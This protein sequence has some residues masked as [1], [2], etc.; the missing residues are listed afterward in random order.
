MGHSIVVIV[1]GS[2]SCMHALKS[3]EARASPVSGAIAEAKL[4]QRFELAKCEPFKF[5][6][7]LIR[8]QSDRGAL[9]ICCLLS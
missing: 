3:G 8:H 6:H 2:S 1:D 4:C 5:W 7:E 9:W